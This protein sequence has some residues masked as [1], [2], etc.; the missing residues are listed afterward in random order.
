MFGA[1]QKVFHALSTRYRAIRFVRDFMGCKQAV[2]PCYGEI[3]A[4]KTFVR[5]HLPVPRRFGNNP[6][7]DKHGIPT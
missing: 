6:V 7:M 2:L 1:A 4:P 5:Y 3:T